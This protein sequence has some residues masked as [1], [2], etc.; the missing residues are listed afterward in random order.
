MQCE[1]ENTSTCDEAMNTDHFELSHRLW[2][3]HGVTIDTHTH[4]LG[5]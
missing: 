5:V 3:I 1:T 2:N 4:S